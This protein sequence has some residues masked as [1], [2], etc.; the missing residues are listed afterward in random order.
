[1]KVVRAKFKDTSPYS[2]LNLS[3]L[4]V[5]EVVVVDVYIKLHDGYVVIIEAGTQLSE[6]IYAKLEKQEALYVLKDEQSRHKLSCKTLKFHIKYNRNNLEKV[7]QL[8]YDINYQ[9]FIDFLNH[10]DNKID[11]PC[12]E[13][14]V[15]NII[16]L[17][18]NDKSYLKNSIEYFLNNYDLPIHSLHV[19]IYAISLGHRLDIGEKQLLELGVAA[20]LHDVGKKKLVDIIDKTTALNIEEFELIYKHPLYSVDIIKHNKVTSPYIIDAV[21]HHHE[22]EDGNGYPHQ[23]SGKGISQFAA[24]LAICDVFDALTNDRPSR[25]AYKTFDALKIMLKDPSMA[26]KFNRDYLNTFLQMLV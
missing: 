11:I 18:Q 26:N 5:G 7:I 16:F 8:L 20:L 1:M 10:E 12:V 3:T 22:Q 2:K 4:S 13:L 14:I 21:T 23:L 24:I 19:T 15:Q 17:V 9:L 25:R 6:N